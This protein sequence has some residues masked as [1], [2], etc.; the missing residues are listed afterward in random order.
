ML[1]SRAI[2]VAVMAGAALAACAGQP[3]APGPNEATCAARGLSPG[4]LEFA[5][6]LHPSEAPVLQRGEA[7]WGQMQD[8][9]E[10]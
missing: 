5:A 7:A 4:T 3:S 1:R 6:C 9:D 8:V 10:Q 2:I